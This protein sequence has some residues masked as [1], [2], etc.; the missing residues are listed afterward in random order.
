MLV[1]CSCD[2]GAG[3]SEGP[4]TVEYHATPRREGDGMCSWA[5]SGPPLLFLFRGVSTCRNL[6]V[7][8]VRSTL[9]TKTLL[10]SNRKS[11]S[12]LSVLIRTTLLVNIT[13]HF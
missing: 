8:V 7:A 13:S 9:I 12:Y 6:F 11:P 4:R 1:V 10:M 2:L 5:F 3:V